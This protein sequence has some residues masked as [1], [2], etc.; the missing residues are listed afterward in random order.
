MKTDRRGGRPAKENKVKVKIFHIFCLVFILLRLPAFPQ[1]A[2]EL[3]SDKLTFDF[4]TIREGTNARV[5]FTIFNTGAKEV[6]IREIRTFSSCVEARPLAQRNLGPGKKLTLEYIF[7]SLGYGGASVNKDIEI[8]YNNNRLSPLRLKVKGKV[9][10]LEPYQASLGELTY[11]F[12]VLIDIRSEQSFAQE[13]IIGSINVPFEKIDKWAADVSRVI[14][15][16]LIIYLYSED[17]TESDKAA[18]MLQDKGHSQYV[19][20]VGGLKEW[21]N[22]RGKKFLISGR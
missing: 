20:I 10:S 7:E 15:D 6:Q 2:P 8:H 5:T 4:G 17:G 13:H 14:S 16:E 21:K 9:L 22:Q 1:E 18:K 3:T 19:S 11:N 12:F